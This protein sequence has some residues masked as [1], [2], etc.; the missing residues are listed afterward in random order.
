M[1]GILYMVSTPIGNLEDI[2]Y[3]ALRIL[4]ESD[5]V[6]AEDTR[7]TRHLLEHFDIHTPM[8]SYHEFNKLEKADDLITRLERGQNIALVTDAGTPG[9]SDPG[10][11]LVRMCLEQ[12]I[13]VE[14]IPG[15]CACIN[16]LV[17]SGLSTVR[18]SFEGFLPKDK[19]ELE[20]VLSELENESRTFVIYE[21]PHHLKKTL[22]LLFDRLGD[23]QITLVRE[24]TKLHE[25]IIPTTLGGAL[26]LYSETE[27]RGEY[28][29][30]LA[31]KSK[32]EIASERRQAFESMSLTD[33]MQMYLDEGLDKKDAMKK[34]A[35]DL[36]VSKRDIYKQLLSTEDK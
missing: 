30:V 12:G 21:A 2:T 9:I 13:R 14:G 10:W 20:R 5:L 34:V 15:A 35:A 25:E 23:R 33:H 1:S 26:K 18:F 19:K 8:S 7:N 22:S 17:L 11:E 32:E 24:M 6:A 29:I 36:G 27:P 28:V 4:R 3:R 31:G 16:A